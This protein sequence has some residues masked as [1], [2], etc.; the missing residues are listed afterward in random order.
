[1]TNFRHTS[2][3]KIAPR[4]ASDQLV[5]QRRNRPISP[6]LTVY[7]WNYVSSASALHRITGSLL[8]A[9][10]YGFATLYLFSPTLGLNLDSTTITAAFGF[11]PPAVKAAFKFCMAM[12]FTWHAFNGVKH[13]VWD[14]GRLLGKVQSGRASWAVLA[15]SGTVS[16]GLALYQF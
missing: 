12:S 1:M 16:L 6:H 9:S 4:P 7:K 5:A 8:S 11:L 2:T 10:L 15:C 14:T 13:L 3:P